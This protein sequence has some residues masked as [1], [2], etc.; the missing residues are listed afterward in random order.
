MVAGA[1]LVSEA[2]FAMRAIERFATLVKTSLNLTG[3]NTFYA[4]KRD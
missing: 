4:D 1:S 2:W 3:L